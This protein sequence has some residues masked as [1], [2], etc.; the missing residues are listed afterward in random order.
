MTADSDAR[1]SNAKEELLLT[2][3]SKNTTRSI[4]DFAPE[5]IRLESNLEGE[6]KGVYDAKFYA[7]ITMLVK[8]DR[9]IEAETRQIHTTSDGDTVLVYYKT[10]SIIVSPTQNRFVGETTFQ[11]SS[12]KLAWLNRVK[13]RVEGE[14]DPVAGE[15]H[16]RVY[17]TR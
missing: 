16:Y 15:N 9:T 2:L 3:T 10:T 5:G 6:A 1:R 7:T 17:G 4:K 12:K 14:Y 11:T 13:A 8:P